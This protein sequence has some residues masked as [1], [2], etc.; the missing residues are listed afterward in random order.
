MDKSFNN[1]NLQD[2]YKPQK[3][4]ETTHLKL[5]GPQKTKRAQKFRRLLVDRVNSKEA[6]FQG[7]FL[8]VRELTSS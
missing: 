4:K 7:T 8:K 3:W 6:R 1:Y 2:V 5:T